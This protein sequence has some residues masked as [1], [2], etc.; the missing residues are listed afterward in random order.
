MEEAVKAADVVITGEGS[1]DAQTLHGKGPM[2]VA[3][4]ARRH[5]KRVIA[6]A[7]RIDPAAN[8]EAHFDE[9]FSLVGKGVKE[10]E[11]IRNAAPL[12]EELGA[13]LEIFS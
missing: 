13:S 3:K 7:G 5:G 9:L 2:G 11:A 8:L 12:L 6:I 4:L 10:E 1:L